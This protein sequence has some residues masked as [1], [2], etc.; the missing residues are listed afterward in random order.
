MH[1]R[2]LVNN[3][4]YVFKLHTLHASVQVHVNTDKYRTGLF[5]FFNV[6]VRFITTHGPP[7][8]AFAGQEI[9]GI[10]GPSFPT[11]NSLLKHTLSSCLC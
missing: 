7:R 6:A 4:L 8:E 3:F 10:V 5:W 11:S 1:R 9:D 2:V